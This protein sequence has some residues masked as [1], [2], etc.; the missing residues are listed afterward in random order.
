MPDTVGSEVP[1]VV[2]LRPE[3]IAPWPHTVFLMVVLGLGAAYGALRLRVPAGAM[4]P[5]AFTYGSSIVL[6][7]LLVG[8]TI[9]GLYHRRRFFWESAASQR[10]GVFCRISGNGSPGYV[11]GCA[12]MLVVGLATVA[13]TSG[14]SQRRG[15]GAGAAYAGGSLHCGCW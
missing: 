3:P 8:T 13:S 7:C 10:R 15:A 6:Q 11:A 1:V 5:R 9:A 4:G 14:S 12:T 2:R